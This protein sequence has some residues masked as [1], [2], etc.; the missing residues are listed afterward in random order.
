M[1]E[2]IEA[3]KKTNKNIMAVYLTVKAFMIYIV[4][5]MS[6]RHV[7]FVYI[8]FAQVCAFDAFV[9]EH[10]KLFIVRIH[11]SSLFLF[12]FLSYRNFPFFSCSVY[13]ITK[14]L[15]TL[16]RGILKFQTQKVELK[17]SLETMKQSNF[18]FLL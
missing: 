11:S 9:L 12:S 2:R 8:Y 18:M 14:F 1:A 7:F 3:E 13:L 6:Y 5:A 4:S 10:R 16:F 15:F 17:K